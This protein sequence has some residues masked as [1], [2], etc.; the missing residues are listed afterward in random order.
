MFFC[1]ISGEPPQE[2]VV[3]AKSGKVYERR[4]I[5]KYISENG[6]DPITGDKLEESDLIAI[7][8]SPDTAAPRPPTH[9]SIPALLHLLQNEWDALVLGTHALEQKY[10]ATR[11][12]LS[13]ALYSQDAASRVVARLIRE[14]DAAR[15]ALANV[16][17]TLGVAQPANEDVEMAENAAGE[18]TLPTNIISQIDETHQALSA[19]RKK[20]KPPTDYATAVEVKTYVSTHTIPSLHSASPSGITSL[21]V[22]RLNPSHFLTGGNDK[23]VQ[24]YDRSTDK[25]LAS[26]KGHSKKV[27]HVAFRER[28]SDAT[29]VISAGADKIVKIWAHDSASGEYIPKSTIRSHK[30]ELTG[31]A[32][33]PTSTILTLCSTDKTYSLHDLSSF[34]Q[35]FRSI[36]SEEAF[37]SLAVHPDGTLLALGTPTSTIQ[38]FDIRTGA[39]AATLSSA[40]AAPFTVNSL[41]FSENGY[42]LL[43]PN[44]LSSVAIWDLRKQKATHSISL[45]DDFKVNKVVYDTSAQYFGVAGSLGARIFAHKTWDELL[46]LDEGGEVSDLVFGE[47][48]KEIWGASGR[49]VRIWGLP[50]T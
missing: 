40:D 36:P 6:T 27:N 49:E 23:I 12:E 26:L 11:Q 50:S 41:T 42:H 1:A 34:T 47:Q 8:A 31:L 46:R 28:E 44:S 7:K 29:L 18:D 30:G 10:N 3:S 33:H 4:L 39:M 48:G 9:T 15:E 5:V 24:V 16:Q 25:V 35:V 2:P 22:S 45:G 20:R 43:A 37:T 32:V 14:R 19:A 17:A 13:Y 21:A 38:I